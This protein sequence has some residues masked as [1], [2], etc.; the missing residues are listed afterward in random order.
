MVSKLALLLAFGAA[1]AAPAEQTPPPNA[2]PPP[3]VGVAPGCDKDASRYPP[4]AI[5]AGI[6]GETF[7]SFRIAVDGTTKAVTVERSSGNADLDA[8]SVAGVRCWHYKPAMKDGKPIE[9]PWHASVKWQLRGGNSW[10]DR[11][12]Q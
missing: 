9:V 11:L 10:F 3:V 4:Y 12:F 6:E 5:R 2:P 8:A 7:L 1:A